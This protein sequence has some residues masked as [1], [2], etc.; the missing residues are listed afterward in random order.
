MT[1]EE[2]VEKIHECINE[3]SGIEIYFG[4]ENG[5]CR[6]GNFANAVQ[7]RLKSMF[8][9]SLNRK[10][11]A[12]DIQLL[13]LSSADERKDAIYHYDIQTADPLDGTTWMDEI[14]N[15]NNDIQFFSFNN[16]GLDQIAYLLVKIATV[17]SQLVIY[18]N[19]PP[20][21]NYKKQS[22]YFTIWNNNIFEEMSNDFLKIS[23]GVEL[24]KIEEEL[25]I[26][27]LKFFERSFNFHD[28][29]KRA[30]NTQIIRLGTANFLE[31]IEKLSDAVENDIN[32]AR[33]LSN[34]ENNSP[35]LKKLIDGEITIESFI[36]FT[37][38]NPALTNRFKYS[39]TND[40]IAI[41][42]KKHIKFLLKVLNDDYL[43]SELTRN[44]YDTLAKDKIEPINN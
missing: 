14:C 21:N 31:G 36:N 1:K 26:V 40:K 22:S 39:A 12:D 4:L 24:L 44:I 43:M 20:I 2:L 25:I 27:D 34:L 5:E 29:I 23:P 37:K 15:L 3:K 13:E 7:N 19:L 11:I 38:T 17:D 41:K 10:V 28:Q 16:D 8:V 30:A 6:K 35:V 33:K 9:E 42:N 18:R 32:M